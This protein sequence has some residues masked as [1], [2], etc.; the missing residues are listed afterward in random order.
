MSLTPIDHKTFITNETMLPDRV[1]TITLQIGI[2]PDD[3]HTQFQLEVINSR[4]GEIRELASIPHS[5]VH[6]SRD[7]LDR[8]IEQ[9]VKVFDRMTGPFT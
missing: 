5:P 9:C 3:D 4:T 6:V 8:M 2:M 7:N 1:W